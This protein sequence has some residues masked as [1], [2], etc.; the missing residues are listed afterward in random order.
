MSQLFNGFKSSDITDQLNLLADQEGLDNLMNKLKSI[1]PEENEM[2][3]I[4]DLACSYLN[5]NELGLYGVSISEL[6]AN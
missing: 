5:F 4:F 1:L 6:P 3:S 2:L